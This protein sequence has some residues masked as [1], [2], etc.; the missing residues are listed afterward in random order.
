MSSWVEEDNHLGTLYVL[1][2][3]SR[4]GQCKL[5]VTQGNLEKRINNYMHRHGYAVKLYFFRHDIPTPFRYEEAI[6]KKYLT[7]KNTNNSD[8]HSNEWFFLNPEIL[9]SEILSIQQ[10]V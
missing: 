9:K 8:G 2:A 5:G 1:T 4:S 3:K 6:T 10:G 7:Y